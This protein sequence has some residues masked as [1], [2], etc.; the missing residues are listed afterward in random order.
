M[1]SKRNITV[2]SVIRLSMASMVA[3]Y[4][5]LLV[6]LQLNYAAILSTVGLMYAAVSLVFSVATFMFLSRRYGIS[7]SGGLAFRG[8][9]ILGAGFVLC[10]WFALNYP[11]IVLLS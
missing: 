2:N 3:L 5:V 10:I 11:V 7:S 1:A 6:Y 4:V 9:A 8:I